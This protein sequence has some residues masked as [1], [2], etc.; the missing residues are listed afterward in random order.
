MIPHPQMN[1]HHDDG[2]EFYM[3]GEEDYL[4]ELE[5]CGEGSLPAEQ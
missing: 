1:L 4:E 5:A 2:E 3:H